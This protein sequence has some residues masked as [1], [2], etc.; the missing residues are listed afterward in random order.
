MVA[1][2]PWERLN[3]IILPV[4]L[5]AIALWARWPRLQERVALPAASA[6]AWGAIAVM[7][8]ASLVVR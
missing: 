5:A 4:L 1:H 7:T 6:V 3:I 2:H 8:F